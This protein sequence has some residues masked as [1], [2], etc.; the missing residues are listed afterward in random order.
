MNDEQVLE[1]VSGGGSALHHNGLRN[2]DH[3][4]EWCAFP[5]AEFFVQPIGHFARQARV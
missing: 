1:A 4:F 2:R 5:P 3:R